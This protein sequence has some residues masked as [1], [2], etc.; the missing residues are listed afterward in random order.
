MDN[1]N[2]TLSNRKLVRPVKKRILLLQSKLHLFLKCII[3]TRFNRKRA[4][5]KSFKRALLSRWED[6]LLLLDSL[7]M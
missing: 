4:K 1:I 2:V 7:K 3:L 5:K 6:N